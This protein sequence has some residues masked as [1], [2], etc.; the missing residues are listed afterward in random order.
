MMGR[1]H[2]WVNENPIIQVS[3]IEYFSN[4]REEM[5]TWLK[6]HKKGDKRG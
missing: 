2:K 4:D 6:S 5:P 1:K 3:P